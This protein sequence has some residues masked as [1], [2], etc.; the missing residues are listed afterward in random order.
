ML[1]TRDEYAQQLA[2][3]A[4]GTRF[5]GCRFE[6]LHNRAIETKE[7]ISLSMLQCKIYSTPIL[8]L[9]LKPHFLLMFI[10]YILTGNNTKSKSRMMA[11]SFY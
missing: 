10:E 1:K 11:L 6:R 9:L 5:S 4:I 8:D 3:G 2:V 7:A